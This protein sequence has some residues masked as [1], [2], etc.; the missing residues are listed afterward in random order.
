M[1][2]EPQRALRLQQVEPRI[3]TEEYRFSVIDDCPLDG[4]QDPD[5]RS[6][7]LPWFCAGSG[8]G[9]EFS[10]E[11][12]VAGPDREA[13][14][15]GDLRNLLKVDQALVYYLQRHSSARFLNLELQ[16][17]EHVFL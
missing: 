17:I 14:C 4:L 2:V 1:V 5:E 8:L 13:G 15:W 3:Q 6:W 9:Q 7:G 10:E 16:V 12:A 11:V